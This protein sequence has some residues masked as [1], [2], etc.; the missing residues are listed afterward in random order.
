MNIS[1]GPS[2]ASDVSRAGLKAAV[3]YLVWEL[4]TKHTLLYGAI[5]LAPIITFY[6]G[7]QSERIS[8]GI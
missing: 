5:S 8:T 3:S 7:K 4:E 6:R 2:Q 1:A